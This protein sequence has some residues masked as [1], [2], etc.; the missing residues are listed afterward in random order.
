MPLIFE[1]MWSIASRLAGAEICIWL[2]VWSI[3][4][5]GEIDEKLDPTGKLIRWGVVLG[6]WLLAS[7]PGGRF[8][9]FRAVVGL[10]GLAFLCWPNLAY[11]TA[12]LL[13]HHHSSGV[14]HRK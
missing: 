3:R 4:R 9:P 7:I 5:R 2:I 14:A 10:L 8:G 6:G 13:R 12:R 1:Q 11:H